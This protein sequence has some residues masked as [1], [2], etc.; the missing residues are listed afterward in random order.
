MRLRAPG[1]GNGNF[2]LPPALK[3]L[4]KSKML[5]G[6]IIRRY[7]VEGK[8][9]ARFDFP[10]RFDAGFPVAGCIVRDAEPLKRASGAGIEPY[11]E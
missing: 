7:L 6:G 2:L 10:A 4:L 5:S 3:T 1:P 8:L 9:L 11:E